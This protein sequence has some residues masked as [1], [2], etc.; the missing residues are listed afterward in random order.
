MNPGVV[1]LE[2][3]LIRTL[4]ARKRPSSIDLGLG[5][6]TLRPDP[7]LFER[8]TARVA[9]EGC[10]Y[11][12]APGLQDLREAIAAHY[13]YPG[14]DRA[15]NVCVTTGSQEAVYVA[16]RCVLDPVVDELLIVSPTFTIYGKIAEVEGIPFR[17]IEIDPRGEDPFDPEAILEAI[18][19][20]TR[21]IAIC[22][23]CNPTGTV[24]SRESARRLAEGLLARG[25]EPIVVLHDEIYRELVYTDDVAEMAR[26]YPH[27]VAINSLSKSN[28]LTGLRI[29]WASAPTAI[30][31]QMVKLHGLITSCPNTFSQYVANE[32][33]AA[34]ALGAQRPWY[35]AQC[36]AA[37]AVLDEIGLEYI[38]PEG[39]FYACVRVGGD[40]TRGFAFT[41][42]EERDVVA[43]PGDLF[44]PLLTGWLRASFVT[45]V[46]QLREGFARIASFSHEPGSVV[47]GR[48]S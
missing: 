32:V 26:V 14:M 46:P 39:A 4:N 24:M 22:S 33:F 6:P 27:T 36:G 3:S 17:T 44:S 35:V 15:E 45:P 47:C 31:A 48:S 12:P 40:D 7:A 8:A 34:K 13:A 5:E 21:M 30:I 41:L 38:V 18:G 23:P 9:A 37:K 19:P 10:R 1:A 43:I 2:P 42:L 28:A 11:G 16:L 29:G 20:K 25:G